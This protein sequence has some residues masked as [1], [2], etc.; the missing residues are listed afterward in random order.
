MYKIMF[1]MGHTLV[2]KDVYNIS[3]MGHTWVTDY[4][5]SHAWNKPHLGYQG[6][7]MGH[8][9]VIEDDPGLLRMYLN[10]FG[11]GHTVVTE[12]VYNHACNKRTWV[13]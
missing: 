3:G 4:V 5:Y 8:T 2:T 1:G 9:M 11:M 7:I 13:T 12:D 10:M 6:C